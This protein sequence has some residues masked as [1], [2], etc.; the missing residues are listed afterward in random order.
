MRLCAGGGRHPHQGNDHAVTLDAG[1]V[2]GRIVGAAE[3]VVHRGEIEHVFT[4]ARALGTRGPRHLLRHLSPPS[5]Y[6]CTLIHRASFRQAN[7]RVL[8]PAA[9]SN[10]RARPPR[11]ADCSAAE[12]GRPRTC[13]TPSGMPMSKG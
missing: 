9:P 3:D 4:V 12:I 7:A 6:R 5:L 2:G 13:A 10:A 11:M 8:S 1:A